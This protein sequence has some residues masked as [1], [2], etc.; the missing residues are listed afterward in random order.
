MAALLTLGRYVDGIAKST[1][2]KQE[3]LR[4]TTETSD[5]L[6]KKLNM[7]IKGW[8]IAGENP[9]P[10]VSK[11]GISVDFGGNTWYTKSFLY[12]LNNPPLCFE[13]KKRGKLPE[14][15]IHFDPSTME[16][17]KFVPNPLTRRMVTS[18]LAKVWDIRGKLTPVTLKLKHDLR[19]L[20]LQSGTSQC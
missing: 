3:S 8:A 7:A 4:L 18:A 20:K 5:I 14:G 1:K 17:D 19:R 9:P 16:I 13:K 2:S 10:E 15:T 11:D 12:T 6:Q